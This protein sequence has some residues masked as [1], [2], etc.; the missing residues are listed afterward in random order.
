MHYLLKMK[1]Y[2]KKILC[3]NDKKVVK[4]LDSLL[5]QSQKFWKSF[6]WV[7]LFSNAMDSVTDCF[8]DPISQSC[9]F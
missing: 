7:F 6:I 2:I 5:P 3:L 4:K 9:V 1:E 8:S